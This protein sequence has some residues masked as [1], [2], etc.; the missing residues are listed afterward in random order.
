[1]HER[2]D[3]Y[4]SVRSTEDKSLRAVQDGAHSSARAGTGGK[5]ITNQALHVTAFVFAEI[6]GVRIDLFEI[7]K[8][9]QLGDDLVG[10]RIAVATIGICSLN[11]GF[12]KGTV[13][14]V[15][16]VCFY[17]G[18]VSDNVGPGGL[19]T[20]T[21]QLVR[22]GVVLTAVVG[23]DDASDERAGR[24]DQSVVEGRGLSSTVKGGAV[25]ADTGSLGVAVDPGADHDFTHV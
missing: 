10:V 7:A 12:Y 13:T 9:G 22:F 19:V 4:L 17:G 3:I 15:I 21:V 8:L 18:D 20:S 24:G 5:F 1:L 11:A 2:V 16:L 6:D 23:T 14:L 25:A